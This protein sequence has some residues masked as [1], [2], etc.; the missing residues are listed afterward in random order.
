MWWGLI[1]GLTAATVDLIWGLWLRDDSNFLFWPEA[2]LALIVRLGGAA[3]ALGYLAALTLLL[4]RGVWKK[5]LAPLASVGQMALTNYL[6][7][8][9]AFVLLFFGYGL[10]WFGQTSAFIGL[11]L[12][13]LL[14]ALQIVFSRWWLRHFRFGPFEWLWRSATYWKFQPMSLK[15]EKKEILS[16]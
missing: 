2:L 5:M 10:G 3:L 8:S 7:Q 6:L 13:L 14:F 12:A 1:F 11:L 9:V 4:Q 15:Q 16:S